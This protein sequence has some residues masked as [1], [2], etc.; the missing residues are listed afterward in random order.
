M[1]NVSSAFPRLDIPEEA[2]R[3]YQDGRTA[4]D[5]QQYQEALTHYDRALQ[6]T[7]APSLFISRVLDKRGTVYWLLGQ[8]EPAA[9]D[10]HKAMEVTNDPG[11]RARTRARLGDVADARGWYDEARQLYQTALEEGMAAGDI[12]AI[13]RSHRGLGIVHRRQGNSEKAVF[14]LTQALAAYRQAGEALEQAR[15]LTS[16]GRTRHARGEYQLAISAHEEAIKILKTFGDRW[17]VALCL[18]DLGECYQA[19]Y[20]LAKAIEYHR[21]AL[22]IVVEVKADVIEPDVKRNMGVNLVGCGDFVEGIRYLNEALAM[23]R[24]L[25]NREQEALTLF[26]LAQAYLNQ[27]ELNMAE[28]VIDELTKAAQELNADRYHAL[29]AFRRGELCLARRDNKT[30]TTE[31]QTAMIAAQSSIDQGLLWKLHATMSYVV[32]DEAIAAIH[33]NIAADFIQ[34]TIYPLQDRHLKETFLQAPPVLAVL[35]AVGQS[36]EDLL[37]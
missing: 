7:D 14:H 24:K 31:L 25:G 32:E 33:R 26:A 5:A 18:N 15:V 12:L 2:L 37:D 11:Q 22:Q 34:Q 6:F 8:Y 29:A 23:A 27:L 36:P 19:L 3:A 9:R 4:E 20:D 35:A 13:G 16:L 10:F 28:Q 1:T 30:A 21:Q 17:R